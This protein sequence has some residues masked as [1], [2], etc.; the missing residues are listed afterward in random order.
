MRKLYGVAF[1]LMV[2]L[3]V[4]MSAVALTSKTIYRQNGESAYADWI[5]TTTED[6]TTDTF[7][8]VTQSDVG[9]DIYLSICTYDMS[10]YSSCKWGYKF[11][12]ENVFS[13]DKKL[14][15]AN[16]EAVQLELYQW[17]CDD[18]GCWETPDGTATI[19]ANWVGIGTVLKS[20][21]TWTDKS[22]DYISKSSS[23]SSSRDAIAEGTLN[24]E[25][26]GT[27]DFGALAIFKSVYMQM[28]K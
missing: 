16:L 17:N 11:T 20:S 23:R 25:E 6:L 22:G 21:Y 28:Q 14:D 2:M 8:S 3:S 4:T 15:S 9:T 19:E 27:S 13:M 12:Q 26:L 7:L 1:A 10:Y 5:E 24:N 18:N